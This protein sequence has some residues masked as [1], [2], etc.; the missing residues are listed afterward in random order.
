MSEKKNTAEIKEIP[1]IPD[2]EKASA[3]ASETDNLSTSEARQLSS[4]L[5]EKAL[6]DKA[7]RRDHERSEIFKDH[8]EKIAVFALHLIATG[9]AI[10]SIVWTY[11][12]LARLSWHWLDNE[13]IS[14]IQNIFTGGVLAGIIAGQFRKRLGGSSEA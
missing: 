6:K 8:F 11:H 7:K 9:I 12:I 3:K 1:G 2:E 5:S 13:Q 14:T 10:F 4:G